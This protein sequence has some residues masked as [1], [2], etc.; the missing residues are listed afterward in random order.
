[1]RPIGSSVPRGGN[2]RPWEPPAVTQL[3]IKTG[4]KSAHAEPKRSRSGMPDPDYDKTAE[5][6]P[7]ATPAA[8]FGF[9][10]EWSLPLSMRNED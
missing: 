7:P 9:S 2:R 3:S 6:V 4:T 1:M 5:P 10:F 8:K